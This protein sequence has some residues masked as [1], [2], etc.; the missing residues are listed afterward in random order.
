MIQLILDQKEHLLNALFPI[1]KTDE[2]I[3]TLTSDEQSSKILLPKKLIDDGILVSVK[4]VHSLKHQ[5]P[6]DSTDAGIIMLLSDEHLKNTQ[7]PMNLTDDGISIFF[8]C[9]HL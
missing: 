6:I 1:D 4:D 8:R 7:F 5:S 2:G 3:S 9:S